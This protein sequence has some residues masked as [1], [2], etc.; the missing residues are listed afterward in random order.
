[1][2][3]A[4]ELSVLEIECMEADETSE[5]TFCVLQAKLGIIP[6]PMVDIRQHDD[7]DERPA[8]V[9]DGVPAIAALIQ[10][11]SERRPQFGAVSL[12]CV[13]PPAA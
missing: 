7:V 11:H 12:E 10:A 4:G 2:L 13:C 6:S 9:M 1:M 3:P 5:P 8:K